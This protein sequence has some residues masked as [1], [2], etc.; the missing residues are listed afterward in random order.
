ML[1]IGHIENLRMGQAFVDYIN[2][3]NISC[4]IKPVDSGCEIWL[5]NSEQRLKTLDEFEQFMANPNQPK[6]LEASWSTPNQQINYGNTSG[7][8]RELLTNIISK[9]S[10]FVSIIFI[11]CV[12]IYFVFNFINHDF[13]QWFKITEGY[14]SLSLNQPWRYITPA[15]IHFSLLHIT[16]N[17]LWWWQLGGL[18]EMKQSKSHI[19]LLFLLAAVIPNLAQY[20]I[21]G[22]NFGGLSGVV[23]ALFGYCWILGKYKP[24]LGVSIQPAVFG[25]ALVWLVAGYFDVLGLS[26]AN[27][28]HLAGL[29]VGCTLGWLETKKQ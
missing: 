27:T 9:S 23:Y 26:V 1:Y 24:S 4:Q 5:V 18:I 28:A 3:F 22:P 13:Y 12:M 21:S 10:L 2:G 15:L 19:I 6:Y 16:F 7:F 20:F 25:I 8:N 11:S 29:L 17:L 14:Q